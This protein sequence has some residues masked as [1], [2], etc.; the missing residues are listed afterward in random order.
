MIHELHSVFLAHLQLARD[1]V[2]LIGH[3][4]FADGLGDDHDLADR[5]AAALIGRLHQDLRDHGEEARGEKALGLLALLG[6]QRVNDAV[7]GLGRA[8]GVQRAEHQM[9]GLGSRHRHR[10]GFRIAH[11]ADENDVGILA[12]RGA[13][14]LGEG[15][16]VGAELTLDHLGGL[17]AM[18]ELD[19]ILEADDVDR[20]G[21]IQ[22]VDHRGERRGLARAG[23][24]GDQDHPLVI[25]AELAHDRRE[26]QL[27]D[28]RHGSGNG[29]KRGADTRLLAEHVDAKAGA[30]SRHVGEIEVVAHRAAP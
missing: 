22:I 8:R 9:S 27:I 4:Q 2:P 10:D 30:I 6:G 11:F 1:L 15:R 20:A 24:A 3:D 7:D 16:Q 23:R 29:T 25:I 5:A 13:Y 21:R 19:R 28:A 14:P 26:S 12:H 18:D 17:A